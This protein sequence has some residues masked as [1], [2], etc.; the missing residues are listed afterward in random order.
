MPHDSAVLVEEGRGEHYKDCTLVI[1]D[2]GYCTLGI[3]HTGLLHTRYCTL[4]Y[5]TLEYCTLGSAYWGTAHQS[6]AHFS[7]VHWST[8]RVANR[9]QIV[10]G[11]RTEIGEIGTEINEFATF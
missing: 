3:L 9:R 2:T 6:T 4:G 8:A 1:L 11:M 7:T 10:I 5:C